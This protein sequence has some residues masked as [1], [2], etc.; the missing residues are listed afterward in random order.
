MYLLDLAIQIK[1]II[2]EHDKMK[3]RWDGQ[4]KKVVYIILF[5]RLFV[6]GKPTISLKLNYDIL[7]RYQINQSSKLH[8]PQYF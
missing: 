4:F 2:K 1:Y 5:R 6:C 8:L 3:L 7:N